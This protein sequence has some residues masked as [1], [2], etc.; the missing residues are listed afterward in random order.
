M[1]MAK[2][3]IAIIAAAL[4]RAT[5]A[6]PSPAATQAW[7]RDYMSRLNGGTNGT[8]SVEVAGG[9]TVMGEFYPATN[10]ALMATNVL[11][12]RSAQAVTNGTLFARI[13][14]SGGIYTNA[15]LTLAIFATPSNFT[16]N[17]IGSIVTNGIDT[18]DGE[19]SVGGT[20]IT[21]PQRTIII[22]E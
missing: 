18:F 20:R 3:A 13:P 5:S 22:G 19:F 2:I 9:G 15:A 4:I 16:F 17:G 12:T 7:V 14:G 6:A 10:A 8:V 21:T 11:P 1:N